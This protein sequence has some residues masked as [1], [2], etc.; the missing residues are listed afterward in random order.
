MS[1]HQCFAINTNWIKLVEEHGV[2]QWQAQDLQ[3]H[4]TYYATDTPPTD[5]VTSVRG[6]MRHN[7]DILLM[8]NRDGI[9]HILPGGRVEQDETMMETLIR[10]IRE[11]TGYTFSNPQLVGVIHHK[12][13]SSK[14]TD[15]P[16]PYPH[17]L[18]VIYQV[19][20]QMYDEN[21]KAQGD[22]EQSCQFINLSTLMQYSISEGQKSLL[23]RLKMK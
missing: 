7:N 10:E 12:H 5:Y 22:Y 16:Y 1:S 11:E 8:T 9:Q 14:P 19:H 21:D 2:W 23:K 20:A 13:L 4:I 15:Y 18:Q 17:F 6:I 3:L